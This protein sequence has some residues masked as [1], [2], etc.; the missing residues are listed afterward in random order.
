MQRRLKRS[1]A[2]AVLVLVSAGC[3]APQDRAPAATASP[4]YSGPSWEAYQAGRAYGAE[5][6]ETATIPDSVARTSDPKGTFADAIDADRANAEWWCRRNLP[7]E[8]EIEHAAEEDTLLAGCV[9]GV[10][11]MLDHPEVWV[12]K[13][14]WKPWSE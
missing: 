9:G 12:D 11:P 14:P 7:S 13:E 5:H 2:V 1:A 3:G 10:L 8:L 6:Q 4:S